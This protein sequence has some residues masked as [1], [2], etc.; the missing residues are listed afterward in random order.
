VSDSP[1]VKLLDA[2]AG[3]DAEADMAVVQ[4]T[5]RAVMEKANH[6]REARSHARRQMAMVLVG[7]VALF[8]FLTPMLWVIAEEAF[9][10]ESWLD[11]SG[12]TS[13]LVATM[14]FSIFAALAAQW[15]KQSRRESA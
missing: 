2:L 9:S 7:L 4:R 15:R 3:L 1:D 5:R 10:D 8:T 12:L 6:M 14:A 13:L 11:V